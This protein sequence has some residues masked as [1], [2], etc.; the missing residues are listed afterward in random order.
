MSLAQKPAGHEIEH[1]S[2]GIT[3]WTG[4]VLLHLVTAFSV[5][6]NRGSKVILNILKHQLN[7]SLQILATI[8]SDMDW[9]GL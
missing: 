2:C 6:C 7:H 4:V 5:N 9:E 3:T 8:R 1:C